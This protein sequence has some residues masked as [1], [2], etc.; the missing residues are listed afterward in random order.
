MRSIT[1]GQRPVNELKRKR[2]KYLEDSEVMKVST[3]ELKE[4]VLS[5]DESSVDVVR[6]AK[7]ADK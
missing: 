1:I 3:R 6:I 4:Q 7:Q 5:P 2:W